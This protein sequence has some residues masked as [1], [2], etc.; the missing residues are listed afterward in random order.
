M[1]YIAEFR[2]PVGQS[3]GRRITGPGGLKHGARSM[4]VSPY[5]LFALF[6]AFAAGSQAIG[7]HGTAIQFAVWALIS[8]SVGIWNG[9]KRRKD[10]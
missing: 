3:S 6:V 1:A 9:R 8:L 5:L 7:F 4:S 2:P 10:I